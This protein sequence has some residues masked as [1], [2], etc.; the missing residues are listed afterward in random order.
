MITPPENDLGPGFNRTITFK[1]T[2]HLCSPTDIYFYV[3]KH[4]GN[5]IL[6]YIKTGEKEFSISTVSEDSGNVVMQPV[7]F[8]N[9]KVK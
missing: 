7:Y 3:V 6:T 4:K 1:Q 5:L 2:G 9:K 8:K